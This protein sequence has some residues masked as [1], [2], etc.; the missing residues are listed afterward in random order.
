MKDL[1]ILIQMSN[2]DMSQVSGRAITHKNS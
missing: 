1:S 2:T